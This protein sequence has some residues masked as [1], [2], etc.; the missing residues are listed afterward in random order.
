MTD[1]VCRVK[2]TE[3][4]GVKYYCL[5]CKRPFARS[6]Q[7]SKFHFRPLKCRPLH[8]AAGAHALFAPPFRRHWMQDA[9]LSWFRVYCYYIVFVCL[10]DKDFPIP[11][12]LHVETE[13]ADEGV[14]QQL[15][16]ANDAVARLEDELKQAVEKLRLKQKE[17]DG[18]R[19]RNAS[20][21]EK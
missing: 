18:F 12:V 14:T 16:Q 6:G 9:F 7:I 11:P 5:Q 13:P 21:W 2:E 20:L 19:Q 4:E 10:F 3:A 8:G 15:R 17:F 1:S